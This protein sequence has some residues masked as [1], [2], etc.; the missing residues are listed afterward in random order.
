MTRSKRFLAGLVLAAA[1]AVG[2]TSPALA[3]VHITSGTASDVRT[4]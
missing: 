1:V 4:D 3:N 2:T